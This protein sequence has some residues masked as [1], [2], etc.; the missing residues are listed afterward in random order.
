[1][2]SVGD[3]L[4][5]HNHSVPCIGFPSW[6]CLPD[7]VHQALIVKEED[8]EKTT[9]ATRTCRYP[10]IDQVNF[11][12]VLRST[13]IYLT[14]SLPAQIEPGSPRENLNANHSH[15]VISDT[16]AVCDWGKET[17]LRT[18]V[19]AYIKDTMHVGIV[20]SPYTGYSGVTSYYV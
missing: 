6:G 1:M 19:E 20:V 7:A 13:L 4:R 12:N 10:T 3:A 2:I 15:F 18:A 8:M 9:G 11:N 14:L 16:G 5:A 17:L